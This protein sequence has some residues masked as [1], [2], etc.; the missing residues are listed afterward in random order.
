MENIL[1]T[2]RPEQQAAPPFLVDSGSML[3]DVRRI[4]TK[5]LRPLV[6][7]IDLEGMYPE[8]VFRKFGKAGAFAQHVG[9]LTNGKPRL[10]LAI[11]AM[12]VAGEQCLSTSFCMW[13]QDAL[14]WYLANTENTALKKRLLE[15]AAT[16]TVLGGT[17]LSN[18]MKTFFG[19]E[20]MRLKGQRIDGG[21]IVS[22][23][24]PWVSNIGEDCYFGAIFA[25]ETDP[26]R[27][28][29]M[30]VDCSAPGVEIAQNAH[31][32]ALEGSR[33]YSVRFTEYFVPDEMLLADPAEPFVRT[34]R[35]GFILMQCGM[36]FGL[37][38]DCIRLMRQLE[39]SHGHVNQYLPD[40]PGLFEEALANMRPLVANLCQTPFD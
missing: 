28:V 7:D 36:A 8:A 21:F 29:M 33:T 5:E 39:K 9:N 1:E 11:D 10:D 32:T 16:G 34:I 37:I 18:P 14:V 31:F 23:T 25:V 12:S 4:S 26:K 40:Q 19:I 6:N 15:D 13:C 27:H 24:L 3:E 17:G 38:E 20:T 2:E 35:A 22:G 30:C